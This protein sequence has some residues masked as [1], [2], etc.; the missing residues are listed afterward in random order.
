MRNISEYTELMDN[1]KLSEYK[2]RNLKNIPMESSKRN[3]KCS[4]RE[5]CL[6]ACAAV[7]IVAIGVTAT[8]TF[9]H[10]L[11]TTNTFSISVSAV[12]TEE[13]VLS[14]EKLLLNSEGVMTML[15][16]LH[17]TSESDDVSIPP[18]YQIMLDFSINCSGRNISK[19]TYKSNGNYFRFDNTTNINVTDTINEI[20]G[21][22]VSDMLDTYGVFCNEFTLENTNVKVPLTLFYITNSDQ[23]KVTEAVKKYNELD[24]LALTRKLERID[25]DKANGNSHGSLSDEDIQLEKQM[26]IAWNMVLSELINGTSVVLE[27]EFENGEKITKQIN[28]SYEKTSGNSENDLPNY[29]I[30]VSFAE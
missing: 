18:V 25:Q 4:F 19:I 16:A 2:K 28:I 8:M 30:N 21:I 1:T 20:N 6:S 10:S 22:D 13:T 14:N 17:Y 11:F 12:S 29:S 26:N 24:E 23:S 9:M 15:P 3:F 27:I 5:I 7:L